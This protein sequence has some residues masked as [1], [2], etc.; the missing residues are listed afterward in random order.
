MANASREKTGSMRP[1]IRELLCAL[2]LGPY[3]ALE[4]TRSYKMRHLRKRWTSET[5]RAAPQQWTLQPPFARVPPGL[6]DG[7]SG[8][9]SL[10]GLRSMVKS[11]HT[12]ILRREDDPRKLRGGSWLSWLCPGVPSGYGS[13]C[14]SEALKSKGSHCGTTTQ[15][16]LEL[17]GAGCAIGR[18]RGTNE[19]PRVPMSD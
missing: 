15:L 17:M 11:S 19:N 13:V 2:A 12:S 10:G 6:E 3:A 4:W 1:V 5:R 9:A 7:L 16:L 18:K 8:K 14:P